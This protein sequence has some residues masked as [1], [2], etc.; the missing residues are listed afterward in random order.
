MWLP[1]EYHVTSSVSFY[2]LGGYPRFPP[3]PLPS[4]SSPHPPP[5]TPSPMKSVLYFQHLP[6]FMAAIADY[7]EVCQCH[8]Q[9]SNSHMTNKY[10]KW[11]WGS[12]HS[13][14]T[15]SRGFPANECYKLASSTFYHHSRHQPYFWWM[16]YGYVLK[17][18]PGLQF[19][20]IRLQ[21]VSPLC[22]RNSEVSAVN[23]TCMHA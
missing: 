16:A 20:D 14:V 22:R 15:F 21:K 9:K 1:Y 13:C 17:V 5:L 8:V 18:Q 23:C 10:I 12:A 7:T 2:L 4:P 6:F 3:T 11:F 19:H